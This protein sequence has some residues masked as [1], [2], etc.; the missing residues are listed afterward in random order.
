M[1]QQN[2]VLSATYFTIFIE[3]NQNITNSTTP[4][5]PPPPPPHHTHHPHPPTPP[6]PT[7]QTTHTH[8]HKQTNWGTDLIICLFTDVHT[9]II[10]L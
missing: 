3:L 1:S 5:P 2:V 7:P 9:E 4:T 10:A 8:T 6:P